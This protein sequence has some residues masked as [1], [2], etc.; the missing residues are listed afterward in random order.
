MP[1]DIVDWSAPGQI[2]QID[3]AQ[4]VVPGTPVTHTGVKVPA[5]SQTLIV[6]GVDNVSALTPGHVAVT[7][8]QT[9]NP[10][11]G[12][13]LSRTFPSTIP[14]G[15][16][17]YLSALP[18]DTSVKIVYDGESATSV[19][20]WVFASPLPVQVAINSEIGVAL[21]D[22]S[23]R[24]T[25][26]QIEFAAAPL[27]GVT[28]S[29]SFPPPWLAPDSYVTF[30][31]SIAA[32]GTLTIIS[33][34]TGDNIFLHDL[35]IGDDG[36]NAA[37]RYHLQQS[38]GVDI[39]VFVAHNTRDQK[40]QHDYKGRILDVSVGVRIQNNGAVA[41]FITGSLGYRIATLP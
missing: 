7:G 19:D 5:G 10:Y 25:D 4:N 2:Q 41:S 21:Q 1:N 31:A 36:A 29:Q 23:G 39:D 20:F 16:I 22:G 18:A 38:N 3:T 6:L 24:L 15:G 26:T 14:F 34:S 13:D 8:E 27:Q 40:A 9:G 35:N 12:N 33:A 30:N 17:L 28:L 37:A 11:L 32:G